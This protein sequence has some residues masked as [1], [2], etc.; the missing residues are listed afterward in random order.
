MDLEQHR[1]AEHL[2]VVD[3]ERQLADGLIRSLIVDARPIERILVVKTSSAGYVRVTLDRLGSLFPDAKLSVWTEE[4]E[5][6]EFYLRPDVDRIV[7]YRNLGS[8][9][10]MMRDLAAANPD[11]LVVQSTNEPTYAK[12]QVLAAALLSRSWL[13]Y[14]DHVDVR[15]A[16]GIGAK[17][18]I[19]LRTYFGTARPPT[20]I[21][22]GAIGA[23]VAVWRILTLPPVI[24]GLLV[25]AGLHSLTRYRYLRARTRARDS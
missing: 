3:L 2:K 4:R 15:G 12:M 23:G 17:I 8:I 20:V 10:S 5:S 22:S 6:E 7:L 9:P 25:R 18:E 13:V 1:L 19:V 24:I 21:L 16:L 11:L 14:D